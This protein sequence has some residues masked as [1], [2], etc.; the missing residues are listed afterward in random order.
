MSDLICPFCGEQGFDLIGLK[1]H[2]LR[3]CE[4]FDATISPEEEQRARNE[5]AR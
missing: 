2:L 3:W 5:V 4:T 1:A